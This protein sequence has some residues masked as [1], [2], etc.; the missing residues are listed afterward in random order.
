M[1]AHKTGTVSSREIFIEKKIYIRI[2][3]RRLLYISEYPQEG[4]KRLNIEMR[5]TGDIASAGTR[6]R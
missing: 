4:R 5:L 6:I 2:S 3:N 1:G